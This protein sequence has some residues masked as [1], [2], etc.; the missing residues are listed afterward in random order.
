MA[1][2][3]AT[4]SY[5]IRVYR[6]YRSLLSLDRKKLPMISEDCM[7]CDRG[8]EETVPCQSV[9]VSGDHRQMMSTTGQPTI[10]ERQAPQQS[11]LKHVSAPRQEHW[12]QSRFSKL[13]LNDF[14]LSGP[15]TDLQQISSSDSD[16]YK[17]WLDGVSARQRVTAV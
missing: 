3:C 17:M 11:S 13:H 14:I 4:P 7:Y 9:N 15:Y 8:H 10:D 16:L 2:Y 5:Y 6:V 12:Q 1:A